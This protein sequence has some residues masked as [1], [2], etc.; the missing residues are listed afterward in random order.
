M[1]ICFVYVSAYVCMCEIQANREAFI[2]FAE[3]TFPV[4]AGLV[5]L[6]MQ[7]YQE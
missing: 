7:T 4:V 6:Y 1:F 3:P 2:D 5:Q